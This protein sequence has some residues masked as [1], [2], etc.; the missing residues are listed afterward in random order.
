MTPSANQYLFVYGTLLVEGN[1][2]AAYLSQHCKF[3]KTGRFKGRLYDVGE[4]PAALADQ[5]ARLF[6]HGSIYLMDEPDKTLTHIDQYEGIA[7]NEPA[8]HEYVR[9]LLP[10]E[11][12]TDAVTCWVY[13]YN[14]P[15]GGL[16]KIISGNYRQHKQL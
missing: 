4:Y 5:S 10:V 14:W 16:P 1:P 12:D 3:I 6:V 8:P 15:V 7:P 2:Y 9:V 13:L 11:T